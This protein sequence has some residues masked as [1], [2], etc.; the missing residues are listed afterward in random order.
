MG[1]LLLTSVDLEFHLVTDGRH[2]E[3]FYNCIFL[4][5]MT[6]FSPSMHG[7]PLLCSSPSHLSCILQLSLQSRVTLPIPIVLSQRLTGALLSFS[8]CYADYFTMKIIIREE[9]MVLIQT[10]VCIWSWCKQTRFGLRDSHHL[11]NSKYFGSLPALLG[12]YGRLAVDFNSV[13]LKWNRIL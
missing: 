5:K 12:V 7:C 3:I 11:A 1:S 13:R 8:M 10:G 4:L 2:Y 9:H 6:N